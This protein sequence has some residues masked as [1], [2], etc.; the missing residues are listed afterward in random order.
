MYM[1]LNMTLYNVY[2]YTCAS[3][4]REGIPV[5]R[6]NSEY[7]VF[8]NRQASLPA[9][10]ISGSSR[11]PSDPHSSLYSPRPPRTPHKLPDIGEDRSRTP[12][13][14]DSTPYGPS[15]SLQTRATE[16]NLRITEFLSTRPLSP[17]N[18]RNS[19]CM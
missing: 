11:Q 7:F 9:S 15:R 6:F 17:Y 10:F 4:Y 19:T 1:Y 13:R 5:T 16:D 12:Q 14:S 3:T 2:V 18:Q 8:Q